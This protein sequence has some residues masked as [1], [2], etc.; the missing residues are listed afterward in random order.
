MP[1]LRTPWNKGRRMP[2]EPL[3]GDEVRALIKACSGRAPTG[4]RNR[5]LLTVLYRGGLR[6]D[7]ALS[8]LPT[9]RRENVPFFRSARLYPLRQYGLVQSSHQ[10]LPRGRPVVDWLLGG[11]ETGK[12]HFPCARR[13][14][15]RVPSSRIAFRRF[16]VWR[17]THPS[18]HFAPESPA[19]QW[20]PF[21]AKLTNYE[22]HD[23]WIV[24]VR[25]RLC[26]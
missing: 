21:R 11:L 17:Y 22:F 20:L 23:D 5:A 26:S 4:V 8:L 2:A 6:L 18:C 19:R 13:N 1:D 15:A 7:E 10:L 25:L 12:M 24:G 3:S 16:L 9:D 14:G